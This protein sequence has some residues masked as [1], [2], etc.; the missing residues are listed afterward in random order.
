MNLKLPKIKHS[1]SLPELPASLDLRKAGF[2]FVNQRNRYIQLMMSGQ[3][4]CDFEFPH[5]LHGTVK[6]LRVGRRIKRVKTAFVNQIP[7]KQIASLRLVKTAVP[8]R[9]SRSVYNLNL[10]AAQIQ[11]VAVMQNFLRLTLKCDNFRYQNL[12]EIRKE[13]SLNCF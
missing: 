13:I 9:M 2:N 7:R 8:G 1:D 12:P 10:P 11:T 5:T 4:F 3:N 6:K